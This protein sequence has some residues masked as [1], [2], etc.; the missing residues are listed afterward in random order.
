[1]E[2]IYKGHHPKINQL[3]RA[4]LSFGIVSR[5]WSKTSLFVPSVTVRNVVRSGFVIHFH[6]LVVPGARWTVDYFSIV[7]YSWPDS[8]SIPAFHSGF[9]QIVRKLVQ[10]GFLNQCEILNPLQK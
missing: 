6:S 5:Y 10:F 7:H 8:V 9:S 1:M 4:L 3:K 2:A